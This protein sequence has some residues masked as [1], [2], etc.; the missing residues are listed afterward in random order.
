MESLNALFSVGFATAL[1]LSNL[2][3]ALL[4]CSLGT[5][6][7]V[8]PGIGPAATVALLLPLTAGVEP[9]GAL[10]MLA[11]VYY[12]AMFGGSTTSILLNTP[13]EAG[14]IISALEGNKMAHAGRG[15]AALSTAAI[16]SFVAGTIATVLLTLLAPVVADLALKL[17]PAEN[18]AIMVL[19]FVAVSAVVGD[20]PEK[21]F[22]AL[23]IGLALGMIGIEEQS[24]QARFTFGILE[25]T[26]GIDIVVVAMGLFAV[27]ETLYTATYEN[28][29]KSRL[30][31]ITGSI[32]MSAGDW[33]RSWKP[34]LRGTLIGFPFGTIPA[35][36]TE[37]P[38][39]LSYSTEKKLASHPEEFGK[40]AIE[41]VAGPEAANNAAATGTL[42]P[43]LTL[44]IPTSA[45]AAIMLS[46]FQQYNIT[47]G[48]LLFDTNP[49]LVWGLIAS[50]YIGNVMLLVLNLPLVGIWVQLLRIPRPLL[51][52]GI[53]VL[54]TL[55]AYSLRQSWFDLLLLYMVGVLGFA[56]KRFEIPVVPLIVGLIL[57][58]MAEKHFRRAMTISQGD[59]T[60]FFTRPGSLTILIIA[61]L[62]LVLPP[63]LKQWRALR[64]G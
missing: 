46:A 7:G 14:S 15:G 37:M 57:G 55:G 18:F 2:L 24:G 42:V 29:I 9:T 60:T 56:M 5:A 11:G 48:P 61:G 16:G 20:M 33:R 59:I 27:G 38:T 25:L 3:W 13:G 49:E 64:R 30:E 51:Y 52:G 8:L 36:G 63:L 39:F 10:I 35:G 43:L 31:R 21:G 58:P 40:G 34:W 12:G 47:P 45:T 54:A 22:V 28:R 50:L 19:A 62:L 53:V 23:F 4:G 32:W 41:G 6:I 17:G 26:D 44:G 1:S